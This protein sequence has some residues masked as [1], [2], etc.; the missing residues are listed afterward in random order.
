[1]FGEFNEATNQ[2]PSSPN[3]RIA[4]YCICEYVFG[5]TKIDCVGH[6]GKTDVVPK[7]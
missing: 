5:Q 3:I 4:K 1:M 6:P 7:I 2:K